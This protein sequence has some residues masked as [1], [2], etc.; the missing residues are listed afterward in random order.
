[1]F[2]QVSACNVHTRVYLLF[3]GNTYI[4]KYVSYGR[5]GKI[6]YI[7]LYAHYINCISCF[8]SSSTM[9]SMCAYE[10]K[11]NK[12]YCTRAQIASDGDRSTRCFFFMKIKVK[13]TYATCEMNELSMNV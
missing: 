3:D 10:T 1:M 9:Y 8:N 5:T 12:D 11:K 13:Q 2:I 6:V 4:Q 7:Q